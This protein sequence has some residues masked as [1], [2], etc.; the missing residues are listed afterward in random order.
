MSLVDVGSPKGFEPTANLGCVEHLINSCERA[1]VEL[2][3]APSLEWKNC[4][5][6]TDATES[7]VNFFIFCLSL[8]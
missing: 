4:T 7:V 8:S 2:R 3:R 6:I 5:L 1:E